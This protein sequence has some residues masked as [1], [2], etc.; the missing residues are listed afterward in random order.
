MIHSKNHLLKYREILRKQEHLVEKLTLKREDEILKFKE[1]FSARFVAILSIFSLLLNMFS[2]AAVVMAE[3][4][5]EK[6]EEE[7]EIT[8]LELW[9]NADPGAGSSSP[10]LGDLVAEGEIGEDKIT[11]RLPADFT[12]EELEQLGIGVAYI[13]KIEATDGATIR[14]EDQVPMDWSAGMTYALFLDEPGWDR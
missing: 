4:E 14:Q 3:E 7:L 13:L 1:L 9:T 10:I 8:S 12:E 2:P 6:E 11:L 5:G